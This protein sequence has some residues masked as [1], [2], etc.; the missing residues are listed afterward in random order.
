MHPGRRAVRALFALIALSSAAAQAGTITVTTLADEDRAA[1]DSPAG[2]GCS[3]REAMQLHFNNNGLAYKQCTISGFAAGASDTIQFNVNGTITINSP[4]TVVGHGPLPDVAGS[5]GSGPLVIDGSGHTVTFSCTN[6][7]M[8]LVK[9]NSSLTLTNV[10]F[11]NCTAAGGGIAIDS[12]TSGGGNLTLNVVT[13]TNIHSNSGGA[14]GAINHANGNLNLNNVNF[15]N[16]GT[17]DTSNASNESGD[18]GAMFIAGVPAP[19]LVNLTN[20]TLTSNTARNNGGGIYLIGGD[21]VTINNLLASLNSAQG[22]DT[23]DGGGAMWIQGSG[24]SLARLQIAGSQ[25]LNNTAP[26][27]QGGAIVHSG[28]Q[29][30]F[31]DATVPLAGGIVGS[32]FANNS[33]SGAGTAD[34]RGGSGGAI[35]SRGNLSI[36]QSSFISNTSTHGTGGALYFRDQTAA[37]QPA[38]IV[39][40]TFSGN[41][42]DQAGGAIIN[43]MN[44]GGMRLIND[45]IAGNTATGNTAA[46]NIGMTGGGGFWN[47]NNNTNP[48]FPTVSA[49]NTVLSKNTTGGNCAGVTFIDAGS[50]VQ[51]SPNTGCPATFTAVDPQL[52]SAS[53]NLAGNGAP[54]LNLFVLTMAPATTSPL[55]NAGD[56]SVC[57]AGP[58]LKF[59]ATNIPTIRP[60]GDPNCDIGAYEQS[61][62]TPVTLQHFDVQ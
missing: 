48:A 41:T 3:L 9:S 26:N 55:L 19:N 4:D 5:N 23:E 38:Y 16:N 54:A 49:V 7:K 18:G 45:T 56:N 11:A 57:N 8:F 12:S 1:G 24:S 46:G 50:N 29:L 34:G 6:S 58:V 53:V 59:D 14:G 33:A 15:L 39:N 52:G 60:L 43:A 21:V 51:F 22:S 40:S 62:A 61:A 10:G 31:I 47:A 42:A 28:G 30:T 13:F 36:E 17:S 44:N 35:Y 20:V 32:N 37:F 2:Q 25:F 27:G